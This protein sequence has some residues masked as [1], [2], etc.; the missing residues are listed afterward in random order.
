MLLSLLVSSVKF[1]GV[2]NVVVV[3]VVDGRLDKIFERSNFH[4]DGRV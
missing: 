1:K 3:V 2:D 4:V